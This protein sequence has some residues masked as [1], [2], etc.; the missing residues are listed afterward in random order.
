[1]LEDILLIDKDNLSLVWRILYQMDMKTEELVYLDSKTVLPPADGNI[2]DHGLCV[3][4]LT[5]NLEL[6][7]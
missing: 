1:M 7:S 5:V 3:R 2:E 6:S 4:I